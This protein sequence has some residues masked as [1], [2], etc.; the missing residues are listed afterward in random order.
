MLDKTYHPGSVE[1]E[2]QA[3]WEAKNLFSTSRNSGDPWTVMMPP[4]NVTGNLHIGHA[5][6][7]TLQDVLTRF[8]R[9]KGR[10]AYWQPGTDHAG[11]ATQM[12]VER[13]IMKEKKL[14]KNNLGREKFIEEVW[15]WK[16]ESGDQILNQLKKL[17]CSCDW[18][19][20][21]F[22]MD[23]E[24]SQAV[25]KTFVKLYNEKIIYKDTK[26]DRKSVV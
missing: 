26:L 11:I 7:M 1:K 9:M 13:K 14:T 8:W 25:I 6:N 12:V 22:T 3:R 5:L 2:V 21:R 10:D 20:N 24:L 19:R 15:K 4:P 17:G 18:S 23:K 16:K